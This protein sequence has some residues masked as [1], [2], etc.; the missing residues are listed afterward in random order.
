MPFALSRPRITAAFVV[1]A[2]ACTAGLASAGSLPGAAQD[3]ASAMLAKIGVS[4]PGPNDHAGTHPSV[5]GKSD[6]PSNAA[7]RSEIADLATTTELTGVDKGAAISS[8]ASDGKS[9]A[10][11]HGPPSE[12]SELNET[13]NAGGTGT[14]NAASGGA[15]S[16][17]TSTADAASGGHSSAGSANASS[18]QE[19]DA[20]A[21]GGHSGVGSANASNGQ[22]TANSASGGHSSAGSENGNAGNKP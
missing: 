14:A 9:Q 12:R 22:D 17:G 3:I 16:H 4:V 5:R 19:T 11:K 1:A 2:L 8:A 20:S 21:S 10:G 18:G 15:S 7:T 13:P 6:V